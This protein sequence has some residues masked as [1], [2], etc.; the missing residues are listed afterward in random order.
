MPCIYTTRRRTGAWPGLR[1][2]TFGEGKKIFFRSDFTSK[3]IEPYD[4]D[5]HGS[6]EI[7]RN[8][9]AG[10]AVMCCLCT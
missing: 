7:F 4:S 1:D 6:R 10:T 5:K 8:S 2:F 3:V 9:N